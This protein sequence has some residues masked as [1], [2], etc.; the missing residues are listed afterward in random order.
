MAGNL[1]S[2]EELELPIYDQGQ[3]AACCGLPALR[4][5]RLHLYAGVG[6]SLA[7][8]P[9]LAPTLEV[10]RPHCHVC[11]CVLPL[12]GLACASGSVSFVQ[13]GIQHTSEM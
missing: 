12:L 10:R 9:Q 5:L 2:L 8:L 11:K 3:L 1:G 4:R 7:A 6:L 13:G